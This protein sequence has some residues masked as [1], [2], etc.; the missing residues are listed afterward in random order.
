MSM[1]YGGR[2]QKLSEDDQQVLYLYGTYDLN[3]PEHPEAANRNREMDGSFTIE[4]STLEISSIHNSH[5]SHSL[6]KDGTDYI[7]IRLADKC[8]RV[9]QK[10]GEFPARQAC[11]W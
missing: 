6:R 3:H 9:F 7:G 2:C 1:G 11:D 4:K 10:S 8:I 5:F